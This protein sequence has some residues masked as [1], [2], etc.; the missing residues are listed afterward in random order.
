MAPFQ[1]E[2]VTIAQRVFF[3][4]GAPKTGT[5]YLQTVMWSNRD[6][7]ERD[8][9][10]LPG[11]TRSDHWWSTLA[12]REDPKIEHKTPR[13]RDAW[14]R[15]VDSCA[16][17]PGT[18]VISHEFFGSASA[19]QA[20]R[21]VAALA[22]AEV[23]LV[24]TAREPL[25]L[26]TASWQESLK[27]KGTHL[28]S[29]YNTEVSQSPHVNWNWR[30]L[31]VSEV[32]SRWGTLV[33]AERVHVL[34]LPGPGAPRELLWQ[35]FA[36][37]V[38]VDPDA[39]DLSAGQANPSM[40]MVETELLRRISPHLT[41]IRSGYDRSTWVRK[42]LAEGHLVAR[43]GERFWPTEDRIEECRARGVAAVERIREGGFH[44]VGDLAD[45]LVPVDLPGRRTPES[46]TDAEVAAAATELVAAMLEDVRRLTRNVERAKRELEQSGR[47]RGGRPRLRRARRFLRRARRF[48]RR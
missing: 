41:D 8:G 9:V 4:I 30:A 33:P 6:Q 31:D 24:V 20:E 22:P 26:L 37:V 38:G 2:R 17:W 35:R 45:L 29:E 48:R 14:K 5:T 16:A 32:L 42:Y 12:V 27:H 46:V 44:V 36:G 7:L 23:H 19:E 3:H 25:G 1:E 15:V 40:G 10:L 18:A 21:A 34:P 28:L 47:V 13:A 43:S 39:Y 11:D